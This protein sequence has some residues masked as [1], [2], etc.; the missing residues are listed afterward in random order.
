MSYVSRASLVCLKSGPVCRHVA[1]PINKMRTRCK[2]VLAMFFWIGRAWRSLCLWP[3]PQR[4]SLAS[5]PSVASML[6]PPTCGEAA[7]RRR[8]STGYGAGCGCGCAYA[9]GYQQAGSGGGAILPWAASLPCHAPIG[10][11]IAVQS[12]VYQFV[13]HTPRTGLVGTH[14]LPVKICACRNPR[15]RVRSNTDLVHCQL[16]YSRFFLFFLHCIDLFTARGTQNRTP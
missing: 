16:A 9:Y 8:V 12:V 10:H 14:T 11:G 2:M 4:I 1:F 6:P 7:V 3:F 5:S 13:G 15:L